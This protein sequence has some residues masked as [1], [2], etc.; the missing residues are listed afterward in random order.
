VVIGHRQANPSAPGLLSMLR[1]TFLMLCLVPAGHQVAAPARPQHG[2]G[3]QGA[4]A[5]CSPEDQH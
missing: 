4:V 1:L 2:A 3:L 5:V